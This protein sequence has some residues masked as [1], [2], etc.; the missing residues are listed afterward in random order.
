MML[1]SICVL[2]LLATLMGCTAERPVLDYGTVTQVEPAD[3]PGENT[4][5]G[6]VGGAAVGGV[7][8][9]RFGGGAGNIVAT[10]G[11]IIVGAVA[12][13]AAEAALQNA[14][15]LR[16]TVRLDD[17]RVMTIVQHR[18]R[19]DRVIQPGER[20]VIRTSGWSQRVEPATGPPSAKP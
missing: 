16:Y 14:S 4:G 19:D 11:G 8:G 5:L 15:G 6:A 12:G 9:S 20:V 2:G 17:G 13:S 18:E 1:R 10:V 7:I 3:A